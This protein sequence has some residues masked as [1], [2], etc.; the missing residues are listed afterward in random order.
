MHL[1]GRLTNLPA[2]LAAVFDALPDEPIERTVRPKPKPATG[3]LGNGVVKR[4]IVKVLS[5]TDTPMRRADIHLAVEGL[6][7]HPV[8]M[9]SVSWCLG[10]GARAKEP[11]FERIAYGHYRLMNGVDA[12][13]VTAGLS[14][15]RERR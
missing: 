4:A 11:L 13:D 8:S 7:R 14:S 5:A 15:A 1:L 2:P 3:R 9:E 12:D 6:L 10:A